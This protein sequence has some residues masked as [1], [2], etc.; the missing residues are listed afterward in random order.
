MKSKK[1]AIMQPYIFPY[2][3]Y[4]CLLNYVDNFV[5]YDDVGFIKQGWINRNRININE[6][7]FQFTIPLKR[8]TINGSIKEVEILDLGRFK[9]K[10]EKSLLTSYNDCPFF[11]VGKSY[12]SR[13][14]SI[15]TKSI[16]RLAYES[17]ILAKKILDIDTKIYFASKDFSYTSGIERSDR[18]IK[19]AHELKCNVYVNIIGGKDLY[20]KKYFSKN[21]VD[22]VFLKPNLQKYK[23][24]KSTKFIEG[25]S[26]I[27]LLMNLSVKD[28]KKQLN[29]FTLE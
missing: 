4:F 2:I 19:I 12:V 26:I 18:L 29:L 22:L 24:Y 5:F 20:D 17:V 1:L 21:S 15:N 23:Q 11:D 28:I 14:L 8:K 9:E 25:L 6:A 27:D 3:G 7:A 13:I 10:F 16:S